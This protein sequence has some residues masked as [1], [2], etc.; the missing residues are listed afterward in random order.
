[1]QAFQKL[2]AL[3]ATTSILRQLNRRCGPLNPAITAQI[4][5]LPLEELLTLADVLLDFTGP[6]DLTDWL[7]ANSNP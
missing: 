5:A 7:V 6:Q 2:Q 3:G 1:M 4:K